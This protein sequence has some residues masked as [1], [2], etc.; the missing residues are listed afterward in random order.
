[1][2]AETYSRPLYQ[3]YHA[4][5]VDARPRYAIASSDGHSSGSERR[6]RPR[7]HSSTADARASMGVA[8]MVEYVAAVSA[9]YR[10]TTAT[11]QTV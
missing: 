10:R 7:Y 4:A 3:R 11:P 5:A 8:A 6:L 9:E 2:P 1:V